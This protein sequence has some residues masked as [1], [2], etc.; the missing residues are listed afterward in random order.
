MTFAHINNIEA[1]RRN[2]SSFVITKARDTAAKVG[3][4]YVDVPNA[5]NDYD[6]LKTAWNASKSSRMAL[7]VWNGQSDKTIY[8]NPGANY[9]FRFWHDVLHCVL[10]K[11]FTTAEEIAIGAIHVKEVQAEFGHDS[12]EAIMMY[13]DTIGQSM[14]AACNGGQFPD[15]QMAW[16]AAQLP[17]YIARMNAADVIEECRIIEMA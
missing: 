11:G 4:G 5:P 9:A 15:D 7:P 6:E 16:V 17:G 10:N 8:T 1:A 13:A 3:F 12:L 14:Y 2:L